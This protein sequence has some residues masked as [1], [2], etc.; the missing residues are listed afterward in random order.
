MA[1]EFLKGDKK[2]ITVSAKC[3][4]PA[5]YYEDGKD[6]MLGIGKAETKAWGYD[7]HTDVGKIKVTNAA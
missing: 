2:T 5:N 4:N 1:K 6:N 3:Y 7:C